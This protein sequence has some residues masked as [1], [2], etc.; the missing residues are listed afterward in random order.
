M[1]IFPCRQVQQEALKGYIRDDMYP[2]PVLF[3]F[4]GPSTGK[5]S[6][7]KSHCF[8]KSN[9]S[10]IPFEAPVAYINCSSILSEKLLYEKILLQLKQWYES[11]LPPVVGTI[12]PRCEYLHDFIN[13]L[14]DL[15]KGEHRPIYII[16]DDSDS[17]LEHYPSLLIPFLRLSELCSALEPDEIYSPDDPH[18]FASVNRGVCVVLSSR[19]SWDRYASIAQG[20]SRP[21][22]L[23]FPSYNRSELC[24]I[25]TH[26]L[27]G[28][29]SNMTETQMVSF[30][31]MVLNVFY[32]Q[33]NTVT[34][35]YRILSFLLTRCIKPLLSQ[36]VDA[37]DLNSTKIFKAIQ[38]YLKYSN[39][40]YF[41]FL[42]FDPIYS[43]V[44]EQE[45]AG[46][47]Y[48]G[49][50]SLS[51]MTKYL[52][53]ASYLASYNPSKMDTRLFGDAE[54]ASSKKKLR[55]DTMSDA[56]KNCRVLI[57][58][59]IFP[60]ERMLAIFNNIVDSDVLSQC[61]MYLYTQLA[62]LFEMGLIHRI[63]PLD[64]IDEV[65]CRCRVNLDY[66]EKISK[67]LQFDIH[68]FLLHGRQ[69]AF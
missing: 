12:D 64:K 67:S 3:I 41:Q 63:G 14:A 26:M 51:P 21:L 36:T 46:F 11:H 22:L 55:N 62:T 10:S 53:I 1:D 7:L 45:W 57:G 32:L 2:A 35:L 23:H 42:S 30:V 44:S 16:L 59:R 54:S 68:S 43:G 15:V 33:C 61:N 49:M 27:L 18:A 19:L 50:D 20:A 13:K 48:S 28:S 60:L 4:G 39:Q 69:S 9:Q 37:V 40:S 47:P 31:E 17:L 5:T 24:T 29:F 56:G 6:L 66:I 34:E 52:L 8:G 38:P 65:K 58:P 25:L